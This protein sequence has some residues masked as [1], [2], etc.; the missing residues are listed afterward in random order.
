MEAILVAAGLPTD[1][2]RAGGAV[3]ANPAA[4]LAASLVSSKNRDRAY[5]LAAAS[6]WS[7][8][9]KRPRALLDEAS[10][11]SPSAWTC[12]LNHCASREPTA[13]LR[14]SVTLVSK[15]H[16]TAGGA[17]NG[18]RAFGSES[19]IALLNMA[20]AW[21]L[22]ARQAEKNFETKI[23]ETVAPKAQSI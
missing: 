1:A 9:Q 6:L 7:Q 22:L 18:K 21:V 11:V 2:E 15:M 16:Q 5:F 20:H 14:V 8:G 3:R 4:A 10:G 23:S 19:K 13:S 17:A 12:P